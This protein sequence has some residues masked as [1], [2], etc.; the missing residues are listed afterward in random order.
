MRKAHDG[1]GINERDQRQQHGKQRQVL[2]LLIMP[3]IGQ[4]S[5]LLL[6]GFVAADEI[7]HQQ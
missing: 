1:N 6:R 5:A 4:R 2:A 3:G 7:Q